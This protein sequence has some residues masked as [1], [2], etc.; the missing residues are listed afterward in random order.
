MPRSGKSIVSALLRL[1]FIHL[2]RE[3]V[4][5]E[6]IPIVPRSVPLVDGSV[7][8]E[9]GLRSA[10]VSSVDQP[11]KEGCRDPRVAT[12]DQRRT[13]RIVLLVTP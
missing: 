4:L 5:G 3:S 8:G 2:G 6:S 7:T 9:Q 12:W 13:L 1:R 11:R 10:Q